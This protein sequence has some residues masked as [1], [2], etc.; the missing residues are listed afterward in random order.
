MR[1]HAALCDSTRL[2]ATARGSSRQHARL[3]TH[4]EHADE[5]KVGLDNVP[6]VRLLLG[7]K[8]TVGREARKR[9][10]CIAHWALAPKLA[11]TAR[12]K[13]GRRAR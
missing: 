6:L 9:Q 5:E 13:Y 1:Q 7:F 8:R 12:G 4:L 3:S 10:R 11:F 2:F